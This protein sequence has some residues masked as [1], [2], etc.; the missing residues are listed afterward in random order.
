MKNIREIKEQLDL[1]GLVVLPGFFKE[2]EIEKL[3]QAARKIFQIQ[4]EKLGIE[5]DFLT[6]M[7]SLFEN[8]LET[9]MNCG[10]LIQ[11]GLIELYQVAINPELISLLKELGMEMPNMLSLIHI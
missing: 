11:T 10:K 8:H 4:F 2:E 1:D 7:K 6:Q 3:Y 9:F 5:G